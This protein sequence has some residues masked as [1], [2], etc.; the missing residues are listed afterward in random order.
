[1][2]DNQ[3]QNQAD[4][5]V[6]DVETI[7][8]DE[9][10]ND[11]YNDVVIDEEESGND[12]TTKLRKRLSVCTKEKQDYLDGWQRTK[13]D[14]ANLK[15]VSA[16]EKKSYVAFANERLIQELLPVLDSYTMAFSNKESWESVDENWRKGIEYIYTQF[17]STLEENG[18]KLVSP[19]G[20]VF[21]PQMHSSVE[22]LPV[23][24]KSQDHII[25][26]V[27]Q[28]GYAIGEKTLRPAKVKVGTYSE[29]STN[30]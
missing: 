25:L 17:V 23:E 1:M 15:K 18:M 22:L 28:D 2:S 29:V 4:T 30:E 12:P 8:V 6:E 5:R 3:Q 11:G 24:D 10:D 13:A 20:E 27:V 21:D 19:L 9:L 16:E 26:E 7:E 14:I